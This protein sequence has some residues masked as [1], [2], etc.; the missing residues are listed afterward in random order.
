MSLEDV[1]QHFEERE[2]EMRQLAKKSRSS[3]GR[4]HLLDL[5]EDYAHSA[6]AV[7]KTN[8]GAAAKSK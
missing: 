8:V 6:A 3:V 4:Q 7:G 2:Q 1:K 5:A